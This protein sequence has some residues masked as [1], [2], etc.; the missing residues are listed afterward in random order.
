MILDKLYTFQREYLYG[1][2][3]NQ[4][5]RAKFHKKLKTIIY[6]DTDIISF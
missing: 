4:A 6:V 2:K 3:K 1:E 5:R